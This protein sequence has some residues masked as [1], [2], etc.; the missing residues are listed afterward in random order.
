MKSKTKLTATA[1]TAILVAVVVATA[2]PDITPLP[3]H[4]PP[5]T[6]EVATP[7]P[8]PVTAEMPMRVEVTPPELPA[9]TSPS[10]KPKTYDVSKFR[11]PHMYDPK[12]GQ[13]KKDIEDIQRGYRKHATPR[14]THPIDPTTGKPFVYNKKDFSHILRFMNG[15]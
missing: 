1:T 8:L 9:E 15:M 3:Q 13:P 7:P 2:G 4:T 11:F 14:G 12:T 6:P 10:P 5:P